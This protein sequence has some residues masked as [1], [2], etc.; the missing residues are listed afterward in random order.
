AEGGQNP[1]V[2]TLLDGYRYVS[3]SQVETRIV[4]PD[5]EPSLAEEMKITTVPSVHLQ[6]G[7][8]S[9]VVTQ[10]T[11]ATIT[12]GIIR[13]TLSGKK[14]VYCTGGSGEPACQNADDPE[15]YSEAKLALE[16]DNYEVKP[17]LL[18]SLEQIPDDASVVILDGPNRPLTDAAIA[19][20]DTYLKR[21]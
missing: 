2:E 12:N 20:L 13:V 19:A 8:E 6:Y 16:Q 7:K 4:D 11:Q 14:A 3:P 10:P 18:P 1:Q 5:K 9:F 17:L 15:G 21:G